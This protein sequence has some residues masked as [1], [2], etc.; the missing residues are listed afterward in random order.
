MIKITANFALSAVAVGLMTASFSCSLTDTLGVAHTASLGLSDLTP[1]S[2]PTVG[3]GTFTINDVLPGDG[4]FSGSVQAIDA[5]GVAV[6]TAISFSWAPAV[7]PPAPTPAP[8]P[9]PNM[10]PV[11]VAGSVTIVVS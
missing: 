10:Q 11:P 1:T 5:T 9:T 3:Q 8:A 4:S 2:D 6:G 7:S